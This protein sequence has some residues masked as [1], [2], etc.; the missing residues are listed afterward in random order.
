MFKI[1]TED[2]CYSDLYIVSL[3]LLKRFSQ[4]VMS[5][6]VILK[7]YFLMEKEYIDGQMGLF[8]MVIGKKGK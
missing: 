8:M 1:N 4:M 6:W 5:I 3:G 7:D 2:Y